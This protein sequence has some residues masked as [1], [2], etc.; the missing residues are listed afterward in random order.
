MPKYWLPWL[1]GMPAETCLAICSMIFSGIFE[2]LPKLKVCFA[3]GGG[4]FPMTV[5]RIEHGFQVRPDLCAVDNN[6]SP[7]SYCGKFWVD[8]LVH[9]EKVLEYCVEL[10][11]P[12]KI[13]LGSDYPFPR[14]FSTSPLMVQELC[15]CANQAPFCLCSWRGCSWHDHRSCDT[16]TKNQ[17]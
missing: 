12:D 3:H 8:S 11:G 9:D 17:R 6:V 4:S 7:K 5:G 10:F 1:V 15:V 16:T 2:K 13:C 14:T